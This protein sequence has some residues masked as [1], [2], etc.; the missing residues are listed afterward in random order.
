[1]KIS[2]ILHL[3]KQQ[4]MKKI[5]FALAF[6]SGAVF[7]HAQSVEDMKKQVETL[8]IQTDLLNKKIDLE[9]EL[10]KNLKAQNAAESLNKKS[11]NKA[12]SYKPS[13]AN[14]TAKDAKKTVKILKEAESANKDLLK[15]NNKIAELEADVKKLEMKLE[16]QKFQIEIKEK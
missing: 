1:M 13:D 5:L 7:L 16:K 11:D 2:L 8:K 6:L 12:D 4:I 3:H 10:A 14:S 9:Q 15:S